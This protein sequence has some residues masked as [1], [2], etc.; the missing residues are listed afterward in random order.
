MVPL[1]TFSSYYFYIAI[2][3]ANTIANAQCECTPRLM[4]KLTFLTTKNVQNFANYF[5]QRYTFP[6]AAFVVK[7][8]LLKLLKMALKMLF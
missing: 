2:S 3:N 5:E 1:I 6:N 7:H 8:G 4:T